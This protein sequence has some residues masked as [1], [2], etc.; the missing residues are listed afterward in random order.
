MII[1]G[2]KYLDNNSYTCIKINQDPNNKRFIIDIN[3]TDENNCYY[4][5]LYKHF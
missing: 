4:R 3:G 5:I 2:I 1:N